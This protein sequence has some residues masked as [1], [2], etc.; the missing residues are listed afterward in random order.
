QASAK[1]IQMALD[2]LYPGQFLCEICDIYTDYGKGPFTT[3][4]PFYQ[5]AAKNPWAWRLV[6]FSGQVNHNGWKAYIESFAPDI[7][8]SVHPLCQ[9]VPLRILKNMGG[10]AR[11]IP[12][13][14]VVTDLGGAHNLWFNKDV[15]K[16]DQIKKHGLPVRSGFWD[17]AS[18]KK[19]GSKNVKAKLGLKDVRT[20]L[21]AGGGD[22]VG[23]LQGVAVAVGDNLGKL[24]GPTQMVVICG[25]NEKVAKALRNRKWKGDVN[26]VV[27]GFVS[28]M[29]EWMIAS[30]CLVTKAHPPPL[31]RVVNRLP[32]ML[33]GFLPGQEAGNVPYVIDA[34]FGDFSKEPKKIG[35]TV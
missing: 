2:E 21:V 12:F 31:N 30:D 24:E 18:K 13:V 11:K 3:M 19:N 4:V 22:G 14:T 16:P 35:E 27:N 8:V 10:G 15:D 33:S 28:N 23:G 7:V 29:D 5:W 6:Y 26:V 25:K 20:V 9:E 32:T 34:G 17:A 1:A